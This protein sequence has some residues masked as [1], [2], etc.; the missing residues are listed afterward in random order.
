MYQPWSVKFVLSASRSGLLKGRF[1]MVSLCTVLPDLVPFGSMVLL[2]L[3]FHR[4]DPVKNYFLICGSKEKS[5]FL[6]PKQ[7]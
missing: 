5:P 6:T 7:M 2:G 1:K 4:S 3:E